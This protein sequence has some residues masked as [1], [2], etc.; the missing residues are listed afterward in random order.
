MWTDTFKEYLDELQEEKVIK[1]VK[2]YSTPKKIRFVITEENDGIV[3]NKENLKLHK[4]IYT[5]NMVL[6]DENGFIK[7]YDSIDE[8]INSFCKIRFEYYIKRKKYIL[9]NLNHEIK[10]LGNKKRFL[11]EVMSGDVKLF[12]DSGKTRK[13]KKT[14]R[15]IADLESRGY[16]KEINEKVDDENENNDDENETQNG[17]DYLLRL[18]FRSITEEKI[19]KLKILHP[20]LNPKMNLP[21]Q[22]K[23]NYGYVTWTNLRKHITNG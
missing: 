8:I 10:F 3:C 20:T 18:Q 21:V 14:A 9:D 17:Y 16:D 5:S 23:K 22:V 15:L 19:D 6:F 1:K 11:E 13:S 2:N 7:K 4:Y 12:D